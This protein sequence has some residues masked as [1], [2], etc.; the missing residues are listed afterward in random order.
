MPKEYR[1]SSHSAW[2]GLRGHV[3]PKWR[4]PFIHGGFGRKECPRVYLF[5]DFMDFSAGITADEGN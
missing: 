3:T 2:N 4:K 1:K 5:A